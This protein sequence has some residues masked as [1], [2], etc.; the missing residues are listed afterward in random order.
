MITAKLEPGHLVVEKVS[1]CGPAVIG[2]ERE[3]IVRLVPGL[4]EGSWLRLEM[5]E[6]AHNGDSRTR[7]ISL[8]DEEWLRVADWVNRNFVKPKGWTP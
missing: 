6:P 3:R 8:S 7:V 1:G 4:M 5:I 2:N